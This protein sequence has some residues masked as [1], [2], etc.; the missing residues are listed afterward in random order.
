MIKPLKDCT[1]ALVGPIETASFLEILHLPD[2]QPYPKGLGGSPVN[3][4]ALELH[5]RGYNLLLCSVD[6][7]VED[8]ITLQGERLKIRFGNY[9]KRPARD[10]FAHESKWMTKALLQEQPDIVHAHWTY[11]FALAA[12]AS[13]LPY[14]VTAHDAPINVLKLNFIPYRIARTLMAYFAVWKA[15]H[16]SAVSP[17]VAEHLKKY[18]FYRKSITI[19][20][21]GMPDKVFNR[22]KTLK[23]ED[24][25]ITFATILVGWS[26]YKNGEAA[27]EAFSILLKN[28]P[29]CRLIMFGAGHGAGE[30]AEQWAKNR[31]ISQ[32]IE[33]AGQIAYEALTTRLANEVDILVHPALEEAQPMS[34]IESMAMGIPVIAGKNSGGVPWTLDNGNAG[35]LVDVSK[36]EE[37]ANAMLE[38]ASDTD[39]RKQIELAGLEQAKQ[40]FHIRTVT[41]AYLNAYQTILSGSD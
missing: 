36:P 29:D 30:A 16:L 17:Y 38:L 8:E 20:P 3:L 5:Q 10:F 12:M 26:G 33:F 34:L 18:L 2:E 39:K 15:K 22:I 13:E 32:G 23:K 24:P 6:P 37:I 21:N 41:D 1:I 35:I 14:L 25:P 19:I 11:E 7:S 40:K 28:K 31:H 27:I 9:R 4:M